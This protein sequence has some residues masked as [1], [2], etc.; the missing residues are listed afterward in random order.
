MNHVVSYSRTIEADLETSWSVLREFGSIIYWVKGGDVGSITVSGY[1][2][3]MTRD[4]N[5][6]SV[7][8]VQHRLETLDE[9]HHLIAY[10]L[11]KGQPLGMKDYVVSISLRASA[12]G[13]DMIWEGEFD[14]AP[15]VDADELASN[16][17][18]AYE[19]MTEL[20]DQFAGA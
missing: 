7:G 8:K 15:E 4:L 6:P 9:A 10:S 11:T 5:L 16:L 2:V 14:A 20:F 18:L 13:C 3:G 1:G 19:G 12:D 17:K